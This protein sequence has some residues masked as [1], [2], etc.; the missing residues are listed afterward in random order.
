MSEPT[1]T[2][3]KAATALGAL[4]LVEGL[5][6]VVLAGWLAVQA[7]GDPPEHVAGGLF[8]AALAAGSALLI[9]L[10]GRGMLDGRAWSRSASVVWHVL[11]L[12]VSLGTWN[13]GAGPVPLALGLCAVAIA[14]LVLVFR[15]SVTGWVRRDA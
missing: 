11:V 13:G 2:R 7:F 1:T 6:M 3:P 9:A 14:G 12:G 8:L 5:G 15:R 4:L 10:A